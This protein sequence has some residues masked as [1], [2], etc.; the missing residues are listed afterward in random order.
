MVVFYY[1][2]TILYPVLTNN[3]H[4]KEYSILWHNEVFTWYIKISY[5]HRLYVLAVSTV[6]FMSPLI[7]FLTKTNYNHIQIT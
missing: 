2:V 6:N 1:P 7:R 5:L 3:N 4:N